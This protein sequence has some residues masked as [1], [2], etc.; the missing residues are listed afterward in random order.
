MLPLHFACRKGANGQSGDSITVR[1]VLF[2]ILRPS[3]EVMH[4]HQVQTGRRYLSEIA[5]QQS[6][7][8]A[9]AVLGQWC[10]E[11]VFCLFA[12]HEVRQ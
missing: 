4:W 1:D 10:S 12:F 3:I 9:V 5:T 11:I 2:L 7:H 6:D 8:C